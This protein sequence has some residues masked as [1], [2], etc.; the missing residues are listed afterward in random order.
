MQDKESVMNSFQLVIDWTEFWNSLSDEQH[1][2]FEMNSAQLS[3]LSRFIF[4]IFKK[5]SAIFLYEEF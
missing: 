2:A 3:Q 1:T 4:G 5:K